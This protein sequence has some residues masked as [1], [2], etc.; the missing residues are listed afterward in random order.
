MLPVDPL[1]WPELTALGTMLTALLLGLLGLRR[2]SSPPPR[3]SPMEAIWADILARVIEIDVSLK[4][5]LEE[6]DKRD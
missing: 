1:T 6:L 3:P 5:V 4:R 2:R